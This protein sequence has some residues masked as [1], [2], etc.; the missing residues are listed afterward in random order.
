MGGVLV[1]AGVLSY[2]PGFDLGLGFEMF[3]VN[4]SG[5][6]SLIGWGLWRCDHN[7]RRIVLIL[8]HFPVLFCGVFSYQ[9]LAHF[10][11]PTFAVAEKSLGT[12]GEWV[13]VFLSGVGTFLIAYL[14]AWVLG[15]RKVK[16][17]FAP[18]FAKKGF[19]K[20]DRETVKSSVSRITIPILALLSLAVGLLIAGLEDYKRIEFLDV[21]KLSSEHPERL[22]YVDSHALACAKMGGYFADVDHASVLEG[23]GWHV[24]F[25][26][27]FS[28]DRPYGSTLFI[29]WPLGTA[30]SGI[31]PFYR[32]LTPLPRGYEYAFPVFYAGEAYSEAKQ[33]IV[34]V[35]IYRDW[36]Q[37]PDSE[38]LLQVV[39]VEETF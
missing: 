26:P 1:L 37:A 27:A 29:V 19:P 14:V 38:S 36:V 23:S 32:N 16:L 13:F 35:R 34:P 4:M 39:I 30:D 33:E 11:R 22:E 2:I 10:L 21:S 8:A 17:L 6:F 15:D 7:C 18:S 5:V 3:G 31:L 24:W 28:E 25:E 12:V 20:V 9:L